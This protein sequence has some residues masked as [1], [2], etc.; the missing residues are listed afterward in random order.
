[1]PLRQVVKPHRHFAGDTLHSHIGTQPPQHLDHQRE[2]LLGGTQAE[3]AG[4]GVVLGGKGR[5]P[6]ELQLVELDR[7]ERQGIDPLHLPKKHFVVFAGQPQNEM[8]P[9]VQPPCGA[10]RNSLPGRREVM[11]ATDGPQCFVAGGFDAVF[12]RHIVFPR[13]LRQQI[14]LLVVHA[15]GPRADHQSRNPGMIQ[16]FGIKLPKSRD[17]S[18]RIGKRLEIGQTKPFVPPSGRM[19]SDS[20]VDLPRQALPGRTVGRGERPVITERTPL[21]SDRSVPV[22]T[23]QAGIHRD[24]THPTAEMSPALRRVAVPGSAVA[25]R[26][27]PGFHSERYKPQSDGL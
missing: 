22:G 18:V 3:A 12:D 16:R 20:L 2:I 4:L 11:A 25:P 8:G 7:F 13:Q 19:E 10:R 27:D 1:M 24:L 17:R 9:D 5:S 14:Q 15:I 26:I 21:R 23:A 6:N